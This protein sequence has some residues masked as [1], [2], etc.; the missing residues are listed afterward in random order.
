M[1]KTCAG[2]QPRSKESRSNVMFSRSLADKCSDGI[3]NSFE[4][5][6]DCGAVCIT[7][8][9]LCGTGKTC[10]SEYDCQSNMCSTTKFCI[11]EYSVS[12][13]C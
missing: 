5:D 11:G 1:N 13:I 3:K 2:K 6:I 9:P 4:A 8:N 7:R 12:K 10:L